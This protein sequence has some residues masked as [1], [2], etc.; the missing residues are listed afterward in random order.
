MKGA[1]CERNQKDL[2]AY[3][4]VSNNQWT[5]SS[6][7]TPVSQRLLREETHLK[8]ADHPNLI[9]FCGVSPWKLIK[10]APTPGLV[11][12]YCENGT[13]SGYLENLR[14]KGHINPG[15]RL[16]IVNLFI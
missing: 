2:P 11:S 4:R 7:L 1:H 14:K 15:I 12:F 5:L 3:L 16:N 6:S 9:K 8:A 13:V 10:N